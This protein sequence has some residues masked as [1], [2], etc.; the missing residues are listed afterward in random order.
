MV[1][2]T[3]KA[4]STKAVIL[5]RLR[6]L[7]GEP[8]SGE[9][10]ADDAGVSRVAVWKAAEA[11][12]EA[13]YAIS[14][15]TEGYRL[16]PAAPD[17]FLHPWEFPG[18]EDRFR[19]W[20]ETGSTMDRAREL[21][22]RGSGAGTVAV[23][24]RQSAGRGRIGRSWASEDG[25]LFFTMVLG[26]GQAIQRYARAGM[27]VQIAV[28]RAVSA[29]VGAEA[30]LRWPN[31]VYVRGRKIA[32][33]LTELRG[34][35]DRV[36]WIC[37]G[38]GVNVNNAPRLERATSCAALLGHALSRRKLLSAILSELEG[39]HRIGA[40]DAALADAWN[41][42]AEGRGADV[43]V[44]E[45]SH[46]DGERAVMRDRGRFRGA[47]GWGRAVLETEN[48]VIELEAGTASLAFDPNL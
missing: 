30:R 7:V 3:P 5:N 46:G 45:A 11:L 28:A 31:D 48:G 17:D 38:V 1:N 2:A 29:T 33:I 23:A 21:A 39:P 40:E 25:G 43:S 42:L 41:A 16:D 47:D 35:A 8:I 4:P 19:H 32:G 13:G 22:D 12:R 24:E 26:G 14:A 6:E 34:E 20:T 9:R 36:R 44:T 37:A 18:R 15:D 10:L 27:A